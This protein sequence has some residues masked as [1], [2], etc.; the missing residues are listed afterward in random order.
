MYVKQVLL[1]AAVAAVANS[2]IHEVK[3]GDGTLKFDPET[4]NPKVGDTVVFHI[5]AGHNV[6]STSFDTPCVFNDNSWYS[7]SYSDTD[8]GRKKFV[9][10]V[11]SEDPVCITHTNLSSGNETLMLW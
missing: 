11:T 6:I 5:F 8:N 7:G 2:E 10:N 9:V 3:V 4:L 1:T